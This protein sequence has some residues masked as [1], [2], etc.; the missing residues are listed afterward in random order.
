M[1]LIFSLLFLFNISTLLSNEEISYPQC[2][3]HFGNILFKAI[4]DFY[5]KYPE[6][7]LQNQ[8]ID[9]QLIEK[10]LSKRNKNLGLSQF[11]DINN[12]TILTI[13]DLSEWLDL[14][15]KNASEF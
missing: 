5:T 13:K 10:F 7:N 6:Y 8:K 15:V 1:K 12:I 3:R 4:D 9:T 2:E 14:S 11:L